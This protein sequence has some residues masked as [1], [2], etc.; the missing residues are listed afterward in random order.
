MEPFVE[1]MIV[2][3]DELNTRLENLNKFMADEKFLELD[4]ESQSLM[5]DQQYHMTQYLEI[6]KKRI[7]YVT[8]KRD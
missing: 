2:E 6:L 3:R 8:S 1:R 5:I 4:S 7:D